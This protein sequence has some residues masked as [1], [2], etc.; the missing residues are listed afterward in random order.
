FRLKIKKENKE[1]NIDF[2]EEVSGISSILSLVRKALNRG[3]LWDI[4]CL[5]IYFPVMQDV[6]TEDKYT[7]DKLFSGDGLASVWS[8][9]RGRLIKSE[10]LKYLLENE[11][12]NDFDS[13]V[14]G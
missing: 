14:D 7:E 2:V 10:D 13:Y 5:N 11:E 1:E 12:K 3:L 4:S 8:K 9:S 6:Y